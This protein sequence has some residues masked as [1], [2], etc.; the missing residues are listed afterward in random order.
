MQKQMLDSNKQNV[1][2]VLDEYYNPRNLNE[3]AHL[4]DLVEEEMRSKGLDPLNK[5]DVQMYWK[6]KGIVVNG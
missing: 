3:K 5:N 2:K 4:S 6:S 1:S